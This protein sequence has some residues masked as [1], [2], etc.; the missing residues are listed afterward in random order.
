MP[1]IHLIRHGHVNPGDRGCADPGLDD[2][3]L[4]QAASLA[5]HLAGRFPRPLPMLSSPL[6]RCRQTAAPL[7]RLWNSMPAIDARVSEIPSPSAEP[8][9]RK[10]W[11]TQMLAA[12]WPDAASP[13]SAD[14]FAMRLSAWQSGVLAA[15][16]ECAEDTLVFSHYFAINWLC[17]AASGSVRI[18]RF[19]PAHTAM[20]S[21]EVDRGVLSLIETA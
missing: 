9:A 18:D 21:C 20:I 7:A 15:V 1:K 10:A 2:L 13:D 12:S 11:L 6:R 4:A 8:A 16:A 17:S 19:R 14:G 5:Q 3:G